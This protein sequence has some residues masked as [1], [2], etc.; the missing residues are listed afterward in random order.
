M[1]SFLVLFIFLIFLKERE[2]LVREIAKI[3][4]IGGVC[5][6]SFVIGIWRYQTTELKIKENKLKR[7]NDTT[8]EVV[9]IGRV[10][11]EPEVGEKSKK[12]VINVEN[13]ENKDQKEIENLK[14]K[15][16]VIT[17]RYSQYQYN[18]R[19]KIKGKLE[20]PPLFEGFDYRD[21]LARK[22]IYSVVY[23]PEIE[24]L[25][26]PISRG[27]GW[28]YEKI[29]VFKEKL[30]KVVYQNLSPPQSLVLG[31]VILGDKN[32]LPRDLKEKLNAAGLRHI[33]A[34]SGMHIA[35]LS[36]ILMSFFLNLGFWRKQAFYLTI[37]LISFFVVIT[38]FQPSAIRAGI[39]GG[40][41][42]LGQ[43]AGRIA[44][45]SRSVL[46]AGFI[47]LAINPLLIKDVGFQ[48]SFLAV[49]GIIYLGPIFQKWFRK[50]P[51][52]RFLNLRSILSTSL[53]AQVF[54]LPILAYNF[55][56]ISVVAPITN[57]LVL[58]FVYWIMILGLV[59]VLLGAVWQLLAWVFSFPCWLFLTYLIKITEV[60]SQSWAV[61][62]I[63]NFS[64]FLFFLFY[65]ILIV[66]IYFQ[67]KKLKF[68]FL[69]Y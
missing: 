56:R 15:V 35:I 32:R 57:L 69:E 58:P 20:A 40:L 24:I 14:T 34:I 31:A 17:N 1:L 30:R 38:G 4:I 43:V 26:S 39:V 59:F 19:L 46:L 62:R 66:F 11:K 48:L 47:M 67:R 18:D 2:N 36:G 61:K 13:I 22:G 23:W 25:D 33:T 12:L 54:T 63:E 60:F 29:L 64:L 41:F 21:Y 42:L 51:E 37:F 50:I 10:S 8:E 45:A 44:V 3:I 68:E 28:I 9:L 49:L 52:V 65:G 7:Y 6:V 27:L 16:L 5:F 55:G 53:S